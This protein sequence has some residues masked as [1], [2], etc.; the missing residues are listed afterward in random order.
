MGRNPTLRYLYLLS[1]RQADLQWAQSGRSE[2]FD[3]H[4]WKT[5]GGSAV[6]ENLSIVSSSHKPSPDVAQERKT[7]LAGTPFA[8]CDDY[9]QNEEEAPRSSIRILR[10]P[11]AGRGNLS[12]DDRRSPSGT[13]RRPADRCRGAVDVQ[14]SLAP[15]PPSGGYFRFGVGC[16][17]AF[18]FYNWDRF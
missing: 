3:A 8:L 14:Q 1:P 10:T 12:S 13:G 7:A 16:G 17:L 6:K 15:L 9:H 4:L 5:E 11:R 18:V 2:I